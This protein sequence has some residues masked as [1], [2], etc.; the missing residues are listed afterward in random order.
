MIMPG[1]YLGTS[2]FTNLKFMAGV[3]FAPFEPYWQQAEA[4]F[5]TLGPGDA[6]MRH[7]M[8]MHH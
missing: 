1:K 5:N 2:I 3:F 7:R 6:Y 8:Y 4:S